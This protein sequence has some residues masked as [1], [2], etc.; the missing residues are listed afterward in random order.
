MIRTRWLSFVVWMAIVVSNITVETTFAYNNIRIVS[1]N[2]LAQ[3]YV[4]GNIGGSSVDNNNDNDDHLQW[5]YRKD[6]IV[7]LLV[8]NGDIEDDHNGMNADLVCLQEVQVDLWPDLLASLS[9]HYTGILQKAGRPSAIH[10]HN[11][12]TAVLVR[13][14]CPL[15]VERVESRSRA[16]IAVLKETKNYDNNDGAEEEEVENSSLRRLYLATVHLDADRRTT[17]RQLAST[18]QGRGPQS[19]RQ[20]QLRSLLKRL[21]RHCEQDNIRFK[22]APLVLAGDFNMIQD[23]PLYKML[24]NGDLAP[25]IGGDEDDDDGLQLVDTYQ[26][27]WQAGRS[28]KIVHHSDNDSTYVGNEKWKEGLKTLRKTFGSGSI[29]DYIWT[30]KQIKVKDTL[31]FHPSSLTTAR[32]SWPSKAFPSDHVPI[33]IDLEWPP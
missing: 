17:R 15:K 31:V 6:R 12:A 26:E 30:S 5:E 23:N 29:I 14:S 9:H 1:W 32:E 7:E 16:M 22:E 18:L 24:Q 3:E 10:R 19:Q 28:S 8:G 27:A 13:H 11:V 25:V 33:G 21:R 2:I 20:N 4:R